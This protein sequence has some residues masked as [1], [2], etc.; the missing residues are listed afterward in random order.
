[1]LVLCAGLV[2]AA[3]NVS[4]QNARDRVLVTGKKSLKQSEVEN[5]IK[6]YEWAFETEFTAD[7]RDRF[8]SYTISEFRSDPNASRATIDDIITTLP[9][10]LAAPVDVQTGTR[11]SFLAV[12]LTEARKNTDEN[13]LM[14]LDIY[15][16]AQSGNR[17]TSEEGASSGEVAANKNTTSAQMAT[18]KGNAG[19]LNG[20]WFRTAGSGSR[21]YTGKTQYKSGEDFTFEFFPDG[22]MI[23]TS[24]LDVLSIMQCVIKGTNKASG[25][26][27]VSGDSLTINLGAMSSVKSNSCDSKENYNKTLEPT[28][29]TIKF[30]VRKMESITRLDN[31]T[32]LCFDGAGD[33]ACYEQV[34]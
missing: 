13:S 12:F 17:R 29:K 32:I 26:Y 4:A 3:I 9:R 31:P 24:Q 1:M 2:N 27:T 33:D 34:K 30:A 10:I 25:T 23:Y 16:K 5:L 28:S 19:G 21:D 15:E 8:Q 11:K 6:F 18:R 7:E 22:T 20:K 14:L